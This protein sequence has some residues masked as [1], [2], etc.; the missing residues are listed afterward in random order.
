MEA[1]VKIKSLHSIRF[2][3]I[4]KILKSFLRRNLSNNNFYNYRQEIILKI[5]DYLIYKLALK[6]HNSQYINHL[7]NNNNV[8]V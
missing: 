8:K 5:K 7:I 3:L 6:I 1:R 2:F 4:R